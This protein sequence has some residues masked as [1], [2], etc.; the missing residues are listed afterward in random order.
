MKRCANEK[1]VLILLPTAYYCIIGILS[2]SLH[3]GIF[4]NLEILKNVLS[5]N[6]DIHTDI[7]TTS[8]TTPAIVTVTAL[9]TET[10]M[11]SVNTCT[12]R[13]KNSITH[14]TNHTVFS[15]PSP[16]TR[17]QKFAHT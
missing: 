15:P 4:L 5:A 8:L 7:V 3:A 2:L 11:Y 16:H 1:V 9:V 14:S 10:R 13:N 17:T 6:L 12:E